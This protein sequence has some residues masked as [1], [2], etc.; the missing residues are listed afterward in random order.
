MRYRKYTQALIR[1][2]PR[3]RPLK[4][5]AGH[6]AIPAPYIFMDSCPPMNMGAPGSARA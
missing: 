5:S 4:V 3:P 1:G 2:I 6:I